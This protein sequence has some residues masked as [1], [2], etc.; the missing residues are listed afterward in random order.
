MWFFSLEFSVLDELCAASS[1]SWIAHVVLFVALTMR[2][3]KRDSFFSECVKPHSYIVN[4]VIWEFEFETHTQKKKP[5]ERTNGAPAFGWLRRDNVN[6]IE[7]G[8]YNF[9]FC[10][11]VHVWR[12]KIEHAKYGYARCEHKFGCI[13]CAKMKGKSL[14]RMYLCICWPNN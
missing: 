8:S 2:S 1:F 13:I 4:A 9:F 6:P 10:L 14:V 3:L 12:I 7:N 11:H 5:C